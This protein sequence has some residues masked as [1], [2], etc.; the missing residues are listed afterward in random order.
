MELKLRKYLLTNCKVLY[1]LKNPPENSNYDQDS[2]IKV[3][4]G[5]GV[6]NMSWISS[7]DIHGAETS[8]ISSP[9]LLGPL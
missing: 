2:V 8:Q 7:L 4:G 5:L 9:T 1:K 3:R 6:E